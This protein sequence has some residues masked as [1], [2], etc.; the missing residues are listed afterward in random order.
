MKQHSPITIARLKELSR[1][2]PTPEVL[3][4]LWEIRRLNDLLR[5]DKLSIELIRREWQDAVGGRLVAI[6]SMRMRLINEPGAVG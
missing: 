2:D 3:E 4:L 1:N 5:Q 6:E